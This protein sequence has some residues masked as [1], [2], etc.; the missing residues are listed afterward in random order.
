M[1]TQNKDGGDAIP[2]FQGSKLQLNHATIA[3]F[4]DSAPKNSLFI[5]A[6]V[7]WARKVVFPKLAGFQY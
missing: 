5:F 7:A 4:P 1:R 2:N 3:L 6:W